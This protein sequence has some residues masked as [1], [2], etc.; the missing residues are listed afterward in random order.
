MKLSL[1]GLGGGER[2][3]GRRSR[4]FRKILLITFMKLPQNILT[5]AVFISGTLAGLAQGTAF[6]YQGRLNDASGPANGRYDLSFRLFAT[7]TTGVVIAAPVTNSAIAVTNGLFATL[8]DFG[9]GIFMGGSNWLELAVST[10]GANSFATLTPRQ[11]VTPTPYALFA[12]T[13]SNVSGTV[14]AAQLSGAVPLAQLP[15]TV[16]TNNESGLT[17]TGTFA[18]NGAGVTN[19]NAAALN[20]LSATNFWQ[21]GGNSGTIP[22]VNYLGTADNQ[23]LELH[24]KGQ[25]VLRLEPGGASALVG[26]GVP[27]GAPNMIG[28]ATVNFV[29]TGVV[30]AVIGGGGAT[31]WNGY[32]FT[33]S[34]GAFSDFST[35]GGGG[36][37]TIQSNA[38]LSVIGGGYYNTIYAG[39]SIIGG[40][41]ANKVQTNASVSFIGGGL[42]NAVA[43]GYA[44]V[45]GG[46]GNTASGPGAFIGGGGDDGGAQ[47]YG[48]T[49]SGAA[50][51]VSGGLDNAASANY[52]TV[53]GGK[54]NT[55]GGRWATVAGGSGNSAS[56]E[57][58]T[59]GG[60]TG[61]Q[62]TYYFDTVAGGFGNIASG[63]GAFIGGGGTDQNGDTLGNTA[64]GEASVIGGGAGNLA[65]GSGAFIGGGGHDG[66][67]F[68]GN[69]ASGAVSVVSG[70]LGNTASGIGAFIGGGGTDGS[71]TQ[72][73]IASGN[74]SVI[75]G[76][77]DNQATNRYSVV[78]G[79]YGNT[80]GGDQ[81]FV[82]G[83]Y[84]NTANGTDSFVGDGANNIASGTY[85]TVPGGEL[86]VA[87]GTYSLAAGRKAQAQ[88]QG[89]FVWA[90]SQSGTFSSTANDQFLIRA[91][92]GVG[93]GTATTVEGD[94]SI[95][96][97]TYLF[98][99]AIY[100]RGETGTDHN[101]GLAYCGAGVT[102][103]AAT[104]LPD[105]PVLWGYS[106]GALG[107]MRGGAH[108]VLTWTNGGVWV[109][110][111]FSYSS[112][113]NMKANF[114]AVSAQEV[115]ARVTALP[116]TSW[117]YT[118][119]V[120]ARHIGPM[121]QD[122][123][124]AFKVNGDDDTHINVGDETGVALAAIQGL[125]EKLE[126]ENAE[127][128]ARLERLE[129]L[130]NQT[131]K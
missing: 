51:V 28:G 36:G 67:N 115:L 35:I 125:N 5:L 112:D 102:N 82:G 71:Y 13:A 103:F 21:T 18:G 96:T 84:N 86:N 80:S 47:V 23:P 118:N 79:G 3:S 119:D 10:N 49:A 77:V 99:H 101:H 19:V 11:Q 30:G 109:T 76:G 113:R 91:Q 9:P 120:S 69:T 22:G 46:A 111:G 85:S 62:A 108:A 100:L 126:T 53:A 89:A 106:G 93:I 124:A 78:G 12:N 17:L 61:N 92:G 60:G 48:N 25:R 27:T 87:S 43:N 95:N 128:K 70:G 116:L 63:E 90:D 110:G 54:G 83:G 68:A 41:M 131:S 121:A 123:H 2:I 20:G 44:T 40:G 15:G 59:I 39:A 34:I 52:A 117:V 66:I 98:S 75:G 97:N 42:D 127:L 88:H 94:L 8:V 24:V 130:F 74:A 32:G 50:S 37:N 55:A 65:S 6:T 1:T 122:F 58:A 14:S 29:A 7:N 26:N 114:A 38:F 31:N 105:G 57:H 73:N 129:K 104:V 4:R 45:G 16:V 107:V 64:S 72:P 81:A 33:N 56:F